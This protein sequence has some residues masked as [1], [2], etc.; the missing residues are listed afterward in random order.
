MMDR[1]AISATGAPAAL[2]PYSQA[3]GAGRLV[4][5]SGQLGLDPS[6]GELVGDDVA[7]QAERAL[8]NLRA[9]LDAAGLGFGDVVKTTC[10]L[11]DIGEFAAFN[12]VYGRY[13]TD[14]PPAR[15]TFA[16]GALPKG[17][18]VEIE[19]IAVRPEGR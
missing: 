9:V 2:G 11:A 15:S 18:R 3:I 10:F 5:C 12:A 13:M 6:T 17:A 8:E 16:V 19:A 7:A 4:F 14:P 1:H